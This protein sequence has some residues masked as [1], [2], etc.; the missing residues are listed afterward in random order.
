MHGSEMNVNNTAVNLVADQLMY[1]VTVNQYSLID[2][3]LSEL[4]T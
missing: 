1:E 3:P 2:D 4:I